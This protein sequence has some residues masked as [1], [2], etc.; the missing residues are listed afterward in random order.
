MNHNIYQHHCRACKRLFRR[1][2]S[3]KR[4]ALLHMNLKG[5][6][7]VCDYCYRVETRRLY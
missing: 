7:G 2:C 5:E 3:N 1:D 4:V 6:Q